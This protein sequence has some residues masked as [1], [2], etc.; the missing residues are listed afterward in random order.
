VWLPEA[1]VS[2]FSTPVGRLAPVCG[3]EFPETLLFRHRGDR[4]ISLFAKLRAG[5]H[6]MDK[7]WLS[8]CQLCLFVVPFGGPDSRQRAGQMAFPGGRT[9]VGQHAVK[10]STETDQDQQG[11]DR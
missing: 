6:I 3:G 1:N 5:A 11:D 2:T 7:G 4:G 10:N 9:G 8:L